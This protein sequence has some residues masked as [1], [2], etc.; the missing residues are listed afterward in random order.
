MIRIP[1]KPVDVPQFVFIEKP[2]GIPGL[3][4]RS[5]HDWIN[6]WMDFIRDDDSPVISESGLL[7]QGDRVIHVSFTRS[8]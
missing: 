8:S 6:M 3:S 4:G 1:P 5:M 7:Q 2:C